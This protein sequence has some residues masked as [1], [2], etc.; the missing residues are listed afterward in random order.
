M[1]SH[2][3]IVPDAPIIIETRVPS[4]DLSDAEEGIQQMAKLLDEQPA[5]VYLIIDV[6]GLRIT[7]DDLLTTASQVS[8]GPGAFL[9]HPKI[10]EVLVIVS[11]DN[12][13]KYG[14]VGMRSDTFGNV[15]IRT[16]DT[17]DQALEYCHQQI[18]ESAKK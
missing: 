6:K 15:R 10:I 12:F 11:G 5:P 3:E 9:H 13:L 7:M 17:V 1:A 8:R 4:S 18:A 16:F 14:A 2:I